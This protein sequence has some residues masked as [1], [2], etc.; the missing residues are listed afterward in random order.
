MYSLKCRYFYRDI[1]EELEV[2]LCLARLVYGTGQV[3][4]PLAALGPVVTDHRVKRPALLRQLPN[5]LKLCL[6]VSPA[7]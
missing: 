2:A 4:G 6:G 3:H 5:Q 1:V 7:K